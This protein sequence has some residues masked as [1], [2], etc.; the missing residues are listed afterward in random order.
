MVL[1]L[2]LGT[3][4]YSTKV[5]YGLCLWLHFVPIH[6]QEK[7]K[8]HLPSTGAVRQEL[9]QQGHVVMIIRQI[10]EGLTDSGELQIT[11]KSNFIRLKRN[12]VTNHHITVN[13]KHQIQKQNDT[14]VVLK[15]KIY[16]KCP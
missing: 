9:N 10:C 11:E 2:F 15:L 4:T 16:H 8:L 1:I 14:Y 7:K 12:P 3:Y 5:N 13:I 6:E